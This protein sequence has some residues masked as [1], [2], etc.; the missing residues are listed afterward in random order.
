MLIHPEVMGV[1]ALADKIR[2]IENWPQKGILFH[3]ITPVLQSAE[4]FRLL[5]DLLVYRYMGQKVDVVAGLDARGFIIGAAL[6][7]QL[8]VGFIPIRKK[9][10]LPFDTVSQSYALEYGEATVEIHTDAIKPGARVLLV[11]D[12]V[13]TGGTMLAGV[14]LIR[15]LGCKVI[16]AAAILEFTDL[17]GG[18][19]IRES[20]APL[21]TLCQNKGCM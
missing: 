19:K 18:K 15:K 6:A 11:D 13:A 4:Y 5:V 1:E 21:F 14:E 12:L 8:N 16:E 20:G 9:G 10:K 2:K 3:D 17:D 7:Y